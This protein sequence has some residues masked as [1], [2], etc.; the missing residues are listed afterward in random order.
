MAAPEYFGPGESTRMEAWNAKFKAAQTTGYAARWNAH[1]GW[2]KVP[3][4]EAS[5]PNGIEASADGRWLWIANWAN[6]EIVRVALRGDAPRSALKV[7]FMPDNLRWGDDGKLWAAGATGT[8]T[9]Y[10]ECWAKPGCKNDYAIV[11]IDPASLQ[12]VRVPHP[13]TLRAFGEATTALKAGPEVWIASTPSDRIG[14]M[15]LA[16]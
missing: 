6:K 1:E 8:P 11:N 5:G 3:G 14:Y 4:T 10:F 7:D 9:S 15:R 2:Q 13:N 16:K 12:L